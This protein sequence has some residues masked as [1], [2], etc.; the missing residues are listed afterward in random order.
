MD[1]SS[2][3]QNVETDSGRLQALLDKY[4]HDPDDGGPAADALLEAATMF[5]QEELRFRQKNADPFSSD[6]KHYPIWEMLATLVRYEHFLGHV[7]SA[8]MQRRDAVL[9]AAAGRF[10]VSAGPGLSVLPTLQQS[11]FMELLTQDT[12]EEKLFE[13]INSGSLPMVAWAEGLLAYALLDDHC[14]DELVRRGLVPNF[15]RRLRGI[16]FEDASICEAPGAKSVP[17]QDNGYELSGKELLQREKSFL[18]QV[19]RIRQNFHLPSCLP[20]ERVPPAAAPGVLSAAPPRSH[21]RRD[22]TGWSRGSAWGRS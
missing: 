13:M 8:F 12:M 15:L 7:F 5:E 16:V 18:V 4:L 1:I 19:R 20:S 11:L 3:V 9:Q 22:V 14:A 10:L 21:G 17:A 2:E 6:R